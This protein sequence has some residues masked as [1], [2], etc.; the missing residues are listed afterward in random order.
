MSNRWTLLADLILNVFNICYGLGIHK[1]DSDNTQGGT[2]VP[3]KSIQIRVLYRTDVV[4]PVEYDSVY[5]RA[6]GLP[7]LNVSYY[8]TGGNRKGDLPF[9]IMLEAP[10]K[11][12]LISAYTECDKYIV[13]MYCQ[14]RTASSVLDLSRDESKKLSAI[15]FK[16]LGI[17]YMCK[18]RFQ[19]SKKKSGQYSLL[20]FSDIKDGGK[21]ASKQVTEEI[22]KV[23]KSQPTSTVKKS[24]A[25]KL[26]VNTNG[27]PAVEIIEVKV[28]IHHM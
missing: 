15:N 4:L 13:Q 9:T 28:P 24:R 2:N 26:G 11:D 19:E 7:E 20:V 22:M 12:A 5:V 21:E 16:K 8:M 14:G 18:V 1:M 25:K 27:P 3:E 10:T 23:C 17:E 6:F